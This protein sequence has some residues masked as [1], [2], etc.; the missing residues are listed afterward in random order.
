MPSEWLTTAEACELLALSRN[1]LGELR[2]A[3][4]FRQ[5]EHYTEPEGMHRRWRRAALQAHLEGNSAPPKGRRSK[6][7]PDLLPA[8]S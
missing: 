8:A 1:R 3:G 4:V 2:R 6:L 7:N 5:G